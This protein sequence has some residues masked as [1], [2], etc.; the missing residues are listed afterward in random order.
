[1]AKQ[2]LLDMVQS[3]LSDAD[4]DDVN[5]I[6]DTVESDQCARVIRDTFDQV[7]DQ[8]DTH[9]YKT[10]KQL[11]A[12]GSSTP[13]V[14]TRPEGFYNIEY[15]RYDKRTTS[16]GDP[17]Y[18]LVEFVEPDRFITRTAS[19]SSSD[20]TVDEITLDSGYEVLV[21]NDQAPSIWT[22]MEG[23]DDIIFDSYDKDLETNLQQGKTLAYGIQRPTLSLANASV[24]DLPTHLQV[25]LLREARAMYFD[26][27]KS[28]VT[29]EVDRSR[30][31]AEVRAQ[32][33]RRIVKNQDNQ[34]GPNYGRK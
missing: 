23:Y 22:M 3:I 28:G 24:P 17:N 21:I 27:Y 34:T 6:T 4:G 30:R 10:N 31:R 26:L 20:S 9:N 1:M 2:T 15:I 12:T 25:F 14:M 19:R 8:Y 11:T 32:R 29:R 16:G 33:M 18:E 13:N 7:V 5:S